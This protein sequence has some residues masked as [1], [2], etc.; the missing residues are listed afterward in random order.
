MVCGLLV[1]TITGWCGFSAHLWLGNGVFQLYDLTPE[2]TLAQSCR[3]LPRF[4]VHS[5][6][7]L[8]SYRTLNSHV[9]LFDIENAK[10]PVV[11]NWKPMYHIISRIR[12]LI[13]MMMRAIYVSM[14]VLPVR[15]TLTLTLTRLSHMVTIK[16]LLHYYYFYFILF[17]LLL[18][19]LLLLWLFPG[20]GQWESNISQI[21]GISL[22]DQWI[23]TTI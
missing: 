18:I 19:L 6:H 5:L 13:Y 7:K 21:F 20:Y 8:R 14:H 22:F 12:C 11:W 23:K 1:L 17:L 2:S 10:H 9:H 4:H 15:G 3:C 16:I